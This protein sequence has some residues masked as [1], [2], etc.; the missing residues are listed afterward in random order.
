MRWL[1]AAAALAGGVA[2]QD[3]YFPEDVDRVE[4]PLEMV[5]HGDGGVQLFVQVQIGDVTGRFLLAA[6]GSCSC[7]WPTGSDVWCIA[8]PSE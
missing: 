3:A 2:A 4:V 7:A 1:L 8:M 6:G 5:D